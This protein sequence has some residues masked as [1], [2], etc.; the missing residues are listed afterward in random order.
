MHVN[1]KTTLG[2]IQILQ[3]KKTIGNGHLSFIIP[4]IINIINYISIIHRSKYLKIV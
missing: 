1:K 2:V 4:T 3:K